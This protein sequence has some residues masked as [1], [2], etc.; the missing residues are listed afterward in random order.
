MAEVT[1]S[2]IKSSYPFVISAMRKIAVNGACITQ[3]IIPAMP[4]NAK[5]LSERLTNPE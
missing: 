1:I 2:G 3:A 4:T 5:L